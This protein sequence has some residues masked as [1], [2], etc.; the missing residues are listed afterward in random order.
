MAQTRGINELIGL[1]VQT[2]RKAAG[3]SQEDVGRRLGLSQ[4][5]YGQ[6]E[7]GRHSFT[8][9]QMF[10]LAAILNHSIEYFIGLDRGLAPDEEQMLALY[11]HARTMGLD[12]L[13]MKL[14]AAVVG[15]SS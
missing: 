2:A 6:Y 10:Q 12:D 3:L 1:R 15:E 7:H 8:V 5:G 4:N 14:I 11:R 9:E 13:A